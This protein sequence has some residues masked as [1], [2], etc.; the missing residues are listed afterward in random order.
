[1][2]TQ[3]CCRCDDLLDRMAC[4]MKSMELLSP[5]P[6]QSAEIVECV[7]LEAYC[8]PLRRPGSIALTG[9]V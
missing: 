6:H 7:D 4:E 3:S 5:E 2:P 9:K 8:T 1:M